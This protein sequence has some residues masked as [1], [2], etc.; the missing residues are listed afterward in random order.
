MLSK[1]EFESLIN[2]LKDKVDETTGALIS[3]DLL[4]LMSNYNVAFDEYDNIINENATLKTDKEELLKVNGKLYQ[5]IGFEKE[6]EKEEEKKD[7]DEVIDIAEIINEK[8]ELI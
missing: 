6:P 2:G 4:A 5:K 8:G 7:D 3:E 1:T